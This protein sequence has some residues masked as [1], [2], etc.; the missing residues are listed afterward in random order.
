[1]A[2]VIDAVR[3]GRSSVLVVRGPAGIGKTTLL[4]DAVR[5]APLRVL[6]A[7]GVESEAEF[8][9][10]ALHQLLRPVLEHTREL[11]AHQRQALLVA[12]G[13]QCDPGG[14]PPADRFVVALAVLGVLAAAAEESPVVCVVDDA[15]WLDQ[16]STAV[17]LLVARRLVAEPIGVLIAVRDLDLREF[18]PAGLPE[19]RVG[20]LDVE[21]AGALLAARTGTTVDPRVRAELVRSTG[22]NPLVLLELPAVLSP[23]Q[24]AGRSPLPEPLPLPRSVERLFTGR[25]RGL[26]DEVRALLLVAAAEDGAR[27]GAVL[28]AGR[29]L[30]LP[31][32]ALE[33][34][35][36][37]GLV[38]VRADEV[39]FAHPL[40]RSAVYQA[41]TS[42][43]RR[44]VHLALAC[45][46]AEA[47]DLDRRAWHVAAAA[48]GPD[49]GVAADLEALAARAAG[50]GGFEAAEAALA[51]AA[52]LSPGATARARR[53]SSAARSAWLA[54][55]LDRATELLHLAR[56]LA[57]S[58]LLLADVDEQR[59]W[60]EFGVG[61]PAAADRILVDAA[62]EV[63]GRD[64]RRARR[65]LAAAAESA[66]LSSDLATGAE[67]R[68]VA[69]PL[70]PPVGL[71]DRWAADL[72]SGFLA[73]LE[74]D[75]AEGVRLLAGALRT[76]RRSGEEQLLRDAAQHACYVGDDEAA[77]RLSTRE[78]ARARA[79]GAA[80][81]LLFSLPRLAQAEF[82]HGH[83]SA[84]AADAAEAVRL[85]EATGQAGLAA[86]PL[87]WSALVA[88]SRGSPAGAD[89]AA[90]RLE[91]LAGTQ[92]L[93]VFRV[94]ALE[95]LRW[96][97][98]AAELAAARPGSAFAR[99]EDLEHPVVTAL[100]ALDVV[101]A[102]VRSGHRDAAQQR[103]ARAEALAAATGAPWALAV[104]AHGRG[105]L[106]EGSVAQE[107]FEE[108]LHHHGRASRPFARARTCL[109]AGEV[110]RR[111]RH[112]V[113]ARRHLATALD[114]FETLGADAWAERTRLELRACGQT[115]G[116]RDPSALLRL[117]PQELQVARFVAR[118]LPTR[119]VAA[120]LF[121]SP[122]TVDFHLR[123]V[124][125]KLGISSR[126]QLAAHRLD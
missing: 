63:A 9:F 87:A 121:L 64:P 109:A 118:G 96:G 85:A 52:A 98:A 8:A 25:L 106:S 7:R 35:E 116:R 86:L 17:L 36:R 120:Q 105:V 122:R 51:R 60:L 62:R 80:A 54:G 27:L 29:R 69:V 1:V 81:E 23:D 89:D 3:R 15:H 33:P 107:H 26:P 74:D 49:E 125:T 18:P 6:R 46:A 58:P 99:L 76:A 112:R 14:A 119:A 47:G 61:D 82:L 77:L 72:L 41:A 20:G 78:V 13:V 104:A 70:A 4:E 113:E 12:L 103:L 126:A 57:D 42:V 114:L 93:G 30:G 32:T 84:A 110:L 2:E 5:D 43:E 88:A 37:A 59:A 75:L 83:W 21:A 66:W 102:A 65:M 40:V 53:L 101:E 56:P 123:N 45:T 117:T 10:A 92:G 48:E 19:L 34:A 97:R 24:L 124:F 71:P 28:A 111:A 73:L 91:S 68:A 79:L 31:S 115:A 44:R 94:P 38:T 90:G 67:I 11:P 95:V 100:A 22:G 39:A 55:R 108:A 50:R 16:A